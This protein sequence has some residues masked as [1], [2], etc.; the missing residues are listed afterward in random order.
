VELK[1]EEVF[2][3][4]IVFIFGWVVSEWMFQRRVNDVQRKQDY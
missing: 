3:F 1:L 2:E 4:A